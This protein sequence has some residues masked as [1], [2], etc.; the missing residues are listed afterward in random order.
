[1]K[2][3]LQYQDREKYEDLVNELNDWVPNA[4]KG[5]RSI[6]SSET[7]KFLDYVGFDYK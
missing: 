7:N 6:A 3:N 2:L 1:M 5:K 4:P